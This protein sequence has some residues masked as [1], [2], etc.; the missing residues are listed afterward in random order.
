MSAHV[1][2][3]DIETVLDLRGFAAANGHEIREGN[4]PL[5][6]LYWCFGSPLRLANTEA[7]TL[8]AY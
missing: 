5:H 1:V 2:V 7:R 4:G 8:S 3:W 6:Y